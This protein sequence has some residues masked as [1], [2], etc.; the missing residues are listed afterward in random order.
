MGRDH[1]L[2]TKNE[3]RISEK[4]LSAAKRKT[5]CLSEFLERRGF[6]FFF[7]EKK[8]TYL[9][10]QCATYSEGAFPVCALKYLLK[11]DLDLNPLS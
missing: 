2:E 1:G 10:D 11:V 3:T 7:P 8:N 9:H 4:A 5:K 6:W